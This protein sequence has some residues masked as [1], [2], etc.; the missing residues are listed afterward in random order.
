MIS[1]SLGR[2]VG[3][4]TYLPLAYLVW[5]GS[6]AAG[7]PQASVS[8]GKISATEA[9][10][11]MAVLLPVVLILA[12]AWLQPG[13]SEPTP[14]WQLRPALWAS[15]VV[16]ILSGFIWRDALQAQNRELIVSVLNVGQGDAILIQTPNGHRILVDGGPSADRLQQALGRELPASV[17]RIDLMVLTHGQDDHV[18]GLVSV[19]ERFE[20]GSALT[21]GL[22]GESAAYDAWRDAIAGNG[23]TLREAQAGHW[24]E[25]GS[26]VRLEVLSPP[27]RLLN[28]TDDDVNNASV[29]L[30][31]VYGG[32]SFLLTGDLAFEG[33]AALL[34]SGANLQ[35]TVLKVAHHG[36]D[37]SS[38]PEF[39]G[40]VQPRLA[41]I[42]VGA[43][44]T[45]GHPSPTTR[46]R[47][48]GVPLLRTDQHGTVR[49]RT[50]GLK[51][52]AEAERGRA[53]LSRP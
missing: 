19:L 47:L 18:T 13:L 28:N 38:T 22:Q 20:V 39:L 8:L 41:V 45:Y 26:G 40:A 9:A 1:S 49:L 32:I 52:T 37:G 25:L 29:V 48:Q 46:L 6:N 33:E 27:E 4:V 14:S 24:I 34:Q 51:L 15:L 50:D 5:L 3:E 30:R 35:A 16:V 17:H 36:S 10:L 53:T 44:N 42:S 11:A 12:R 43:T 2:M 31:L 21:T 7:L 23:V